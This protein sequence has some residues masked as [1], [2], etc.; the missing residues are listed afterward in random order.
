M[1]YNHQPVDYICPFC[2]LVAGKENEHVVSKQ[3]HIIY[4]DDY[5]TAFVSSHWWPNNPGH[6]IIIPNEHYENLYDIPLDILPKVHAFAKE[7][8]IAFK[9]VYKCDGISIQ[10]HNEPA[11]NQ[12]VWHFHLHVFPRYANDNFYLTYQDKFQA[13]SAAAEKYAIKLKDYFQQKRI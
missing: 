11:G 6:V 3:S 5:I 2:E 9:N 12:D 1:S 7:V 4:K 10:Q 8:A 13:D